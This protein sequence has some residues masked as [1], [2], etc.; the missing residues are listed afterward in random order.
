METM[1]LSLVNRDQKVVVKTDLENG[2]LGNE[3]LEFMR[4]MREE[5]VGAESATLEVM[6][7][8]GDC[9]TFEIGR[10]I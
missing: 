3:F 2:S 5:L 4:S 9:L 6:C 1:K 8:G 10:S 7:Q